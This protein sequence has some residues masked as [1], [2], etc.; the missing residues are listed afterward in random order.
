MCRD[1]I[2]TMSPMTFWYFFPQEFNSSG[3]LKNFYRLL[4]TNVDQKGQEF[5]ST[6]EGQSQML[7]MLI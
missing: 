6:I 4:S 2:C 5:V 7:V 1:I 3:R